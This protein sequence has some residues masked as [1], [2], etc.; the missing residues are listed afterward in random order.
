MEY[1]KL[2]AVRLAIIMVVLTR[3]DPFQFAVLGVLLTVLVTTVAIIA[4]GSVFQ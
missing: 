4:S 3:K 1:I 2:T